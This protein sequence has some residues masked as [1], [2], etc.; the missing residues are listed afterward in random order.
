MPIPGEIVELL[1]AKFEAILPH[2]DERA[3]RLVLAAEARSLGHGGI[4]AVARAS[5]LARSHIQQGVAELEAG[6]EPLDRVR[7][8]GAGRKPLTE[9]DPGLLP[10]LLALVEPTRRG[11]PESPLSTDRLAAELADSGHPAGS[12][13]V[14]KLL[15]D[16]GFSLQVSLAMNMGPP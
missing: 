13:T 4:A 3:V 14:A 2:L 1:R 6:T 11:N 8:A 7:R 5:G 12:D 9:K 16:N 15:K 10:A